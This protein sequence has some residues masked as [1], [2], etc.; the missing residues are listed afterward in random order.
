MDC[1][2]GK[3]R[4]VIRSK[5]FFLESVTFQFHA[6]ILSSEVA[7]SI[8]SYGH[9]SDLGVGIAL[10]HRHV[11]FFRVKQIHQSTA[12]EWTTRLVITDS[13]GLLIHGDM[14]PTNS[15]IGHRAG[16]LLIF[17]TG[18]IPILTGKSHANCREF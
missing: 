3:C 10:S 15:R 5:I 14:Y 16:C 11:V 1:H 4:G 6:R 13:V 2:I 8:K 12:S 9:F 18:K 7:Q 17:N